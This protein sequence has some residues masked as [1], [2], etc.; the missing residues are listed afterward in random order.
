MG[1]QAAKIGKKLESFG[2]NFFRNLGWIELARDLEIKCRRQ[3][4]TKKTH[5]IDLLC[6]FDN[7]YGRVKQGIIIECK[8]RQMASITQKD[9]EDWLKELINNIECAQSAPELSDLNLDNTS[10]NTGLLLIHANDSFNGEK[11]YGYLKK[12]SCLSRRNPIN[13]F[14]AANDKIDMWTSLFKTIKTT[15][16]KDFTFIYPSINNFSKQYKTSLTINGLFSKYLFAQSTYIEKKHNGSHEYEEP[17]TQNILF[18][19]DEI[20]VDNFKYAWSMFKYYQLQGED[21]YIF[22]FYPRKK[23]DVDLVN[24]KFILTLKSGDMPIS[25][26]EA[27]KIEIQFIDNRSLSAIETGGTV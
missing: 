21:K 11:F 14:I 16:I 7:P 2:E 26:E 8:N 23:G 20:T 6:A 25:D 12:I 13:I 18:F 17:H 27:K 9:I 15:F 3:A 10:I 19:L 1:E 22:V 4:H 24:E 5:G